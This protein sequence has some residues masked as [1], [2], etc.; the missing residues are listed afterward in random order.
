MTDLPLFSYSPPA[1]R[2][3]DTSRAA[4]EGIKPHAGTLRGLIYQYLCER[5]PASD[6][7]LQEALCMGSSTERPRRRELELAGLV[8]DTGATTKTRSGRNATLWAARVEP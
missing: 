4:A 2:H 6:E 8:Y 1:Q 7:Q 3:S 5:G